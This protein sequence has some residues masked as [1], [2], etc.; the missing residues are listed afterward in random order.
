MPG[1]RSDEPLDLGELEL[2]MHDPLRVGDIAP[3]FEA[4]TLDGKI[5]ATGLRGEE[6][7]SAVRSAL[8]ATS[9]S[10]PAVPDQPKL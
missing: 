9:E 1:G 3:L 2:M 8:G 7:T 5:I 4:R 10:K 6:L